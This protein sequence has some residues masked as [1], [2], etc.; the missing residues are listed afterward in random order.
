[1]KLTNLNDYYEK[2]HEKFPEVDISDIKKILKHGW[3]QIYLINS[4]GADICMQDRE[5]WIYFGIT[6]SLE[7]ERSID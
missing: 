3:K 2:V 6:L 1:M 7:K 5:S 4:Y